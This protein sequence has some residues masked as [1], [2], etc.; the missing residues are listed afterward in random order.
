MFS[1]TLLYNLLTTQPKHRK[2]FLILLRNSTG[3][4]ERTAQKSK[5]IIQTRLTKNLIIIN[6]ISNTRQYTFRYYRYIYLIL[7]NYESI[8]ENI[9]F[10]TKVTYQRLNP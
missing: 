2:L 10:A 1:C 9:Y 3:I 4:Y 5:V 7:Y 6:N 8:I